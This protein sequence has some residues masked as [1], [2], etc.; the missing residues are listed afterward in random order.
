M[1]GNVE[2]KRVELHRRLLNPQD[3]GRGF[4]WN[5]F[6]ATSTGHVQW[7]RSRLGIQSGKPVVQPVVQPAKIFSVTRASPVNLQWFSDRRLSGAQDIKAHASQRWSF[8]GAALSSALRQLRGKLSLC[9]L[10]KKP[11]LGRAAVVVLF[12]LVL[13]LS[14]I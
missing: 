14:C 11:P 5:S 2:L 1:P 7:I 12:V 9:A 3:A 10:D 6:N 4:P 13:V 8:R